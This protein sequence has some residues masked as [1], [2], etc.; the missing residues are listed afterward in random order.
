MISRR[1]AEAYDRIADDFARIH[2]AMPETLADYGHR[3]LSLIGPDGRV[4]DV[5]CGAGRD[6]AWMEAQGARVTGI[7]LSAGMLAQALRRVRGALLQG[8][9][10]RLP[11]PDSAFAGVWCMAALLHLP[12]AEAP[13]ALAEM[14]RVLAPR[15]IL[16]L[17][18]QEGEGET[19][20]QVPYR[21]EAVERFFA[22]YA[23]DEA[24]ALLQRAGFAILNSSTGEAGDRRWLQYLAR[25]APDGAGDERGGA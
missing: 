25:V 13:A 20:E 11:F 5:G 21:C 7:D 17:S 23:Q 8:D 15:G 4:L 16:H 6:M 1:T 19:W 14:R 9:M 2:A 10:R 24:R 22:R 3:F 18:L 12:K